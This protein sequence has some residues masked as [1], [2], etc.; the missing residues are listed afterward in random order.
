MFQNDEKKMVP[1]RSQS[2]I[3]KDQTMLSSRNVTIP[4]DGYFKDV[5]QPGVATKVVIKQGSIV[6]DNVASYGQS[7][8][9]NTMQVM[10]LAWS[11]SVLGDVNEIKQGATTKSALAKIGS[12]IARNKPWL[13]ELFQI[14]I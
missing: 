3:G 1:D 4:R 12:C 10:H 6:S 11:A 2:F 8:Q 13:L 5:K 14:K 7:V 9:H